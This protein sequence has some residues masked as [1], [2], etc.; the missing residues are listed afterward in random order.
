MACFG[1]VFFNVY[2]FAAHV[3]LCLINELFLALSHSCSRFSFLVLRADDDY[4]AAVPIASSSSAANIDAR[5]AVASSQPLPIV[6]E[7]TPEFQNVGLE[8]QLLWTLIH[9]QQPDMDA[10][11]CGFR[12]GVDLVCSIDRSLSMSTSLGAVKNSLL[13]IIDRLQKTDHLALVAFDANVATILPWTDMSSAGKQKAVSAVEQLAIGAGTN[14]CQGTLEALQLVRDRH[15]QRPARAWNSVASVFLLGDGQPT[16]GVTDTDMIV[17]KVAHLY[18]DDGPL[19]EKQPVLPKDEKQSHMYRKSEMSE[20]P[21]SVASDVTTTSSTG[22]SADMAH[23]T[24]FSSSSLVPV[25]DTKTKAETKRKVVPILKPD[26][27]PRRTLHK[28]ASLFSAATAAVTPT[29]TPSASSAAAAAAAA[30]PNGQS[31][32]VQAPKRRKVKGTSAPTDVNTCTDDV[33]STS[34]IKNSGTG[35]RGSDVARLAGRCT[36]HSFGYRPD[37]NAVL[38]QRLAKI[39]DHGL[40][41]YVS[42]GA[43]VGRAFTSTLAGLSSVTAQHLK[44]SVALCPNLSIHAI[45][46]GYAH[47]QEGKDRFHISIP[48]LQ[49]GESRDIILGI[50]LTRVSTGDQKDVKV[51]DVSLFDVRL[52]YDDVVRGGKVNRQSQCTVTRS[53]STPTESTVASVAAPNVV[54]QRHRIHVADVLER[55]QLLGNFQRRAAR[56]MLADLSTHLTKQLALEPHDSKVFDVLTGLYVDVTKCLNGMQDDYSY[57]GGGA[58]LLAGMSS[59]HGVQRAN[60]QTSDSSSAY[61]SESRSSELIVYSTSCEQQITGKSTTAGAAAAAAAAASGTM[62]GAP[63]SSSLVRVVD[64]QDRA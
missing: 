43:S 3:Q 4:M 17:A 46:C 10:K 53:A 39:G 22:L 20:V 52:E 64:R 31:I 30:V 28:R 23:A 61:T 48:D 55:A 50:D 19:N 37:H 9:V 38:F 59:S 49:L 26:S 15:L 11:Q 41:N 21:S 14:L 56:T 5:V 63:S 18:G 40:Y 27:R 44:V 58:Y 29:A 42:D 62:S 1:P 13:F 16:D 6:L 57:R 32:S 36:I 54:I 12:S 8:K 45:Q 2:S 35:E 34:A 24:L 60:V 7:C 33:G 51:N 25:L 47:T